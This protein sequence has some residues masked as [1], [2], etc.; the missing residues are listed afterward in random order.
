MSVNYAPLVDSPIALN[1]L[2]HIVPPPVEGSACR[3]CGSSDNS[4]EL[5]TPCECSGSLR[6]VHTSCLQRWILIRPS[7]PSRSNSILPGQ[8][9]P[10]LCCEICHTD[11][12]V[13]VVYLFEFSW[14]RCCAWASLG[15]TVEFAVLL[16]L[17]AVC[18]AMWPIIVKGHPS[19]GDPAFGS[20]DADKIAVPLISVIMVILTCITLRKVF[21]RWKRAN[22]AVEIRPTN[23]ED[24]P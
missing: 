20:E 22:S 12:H 24:I 4:P 21:A 8:Q 2:P 15:H 14:R 1:A 17:M 3:I 7:T 18:L 5:I 9:D 6:M 16:I 10:R 19:G 11:Y 13:K 23:R